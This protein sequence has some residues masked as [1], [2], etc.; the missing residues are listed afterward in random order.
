MRTSLI[1]LFLLCFSLSHGA[2]S[3]AAGAQTMQYV[4]YEADTEVA[5]GRL[6]GSTIDT[7]SAAPWDGGQPTGAT[8]PLSEVR[9]LAPAKPSKVI[10]VGLNYKTHLGNADPASEPPIFL[11]LP[12]SIVGPGEAVVLPADA[13]NVHYE[14][15]MVLVIGQR[16]KNVAVENAKAAIFGITCGNDVSGRSWQRGDLQ[17][18]RAKA[19]DTFGPIGP[20]I[21]TGLDPDEQMLRGRLNG[22]VVQEQSTADLIHGSAAIVSFLSRY[23]TLEPGDLI[24]TGTPGRTG[25]LDPGDVFEVE[26]KGVCKLSNP[27]RRAP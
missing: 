11:K 12:T 22:A 17:W 10:A 21:T 19:T 18:F 27:I 16:V 9:L 3:V 25:A 8:I 26:I 24:F 20:A 2:L 14:S 13:E 1:Y 5:Y 7:L 4:R 15:E 6:D 23:I